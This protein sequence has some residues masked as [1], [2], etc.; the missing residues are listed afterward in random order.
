M[1]ICKKVP[2]DSSSSKEWSSESSKKK[3]KKE[4]GSISN[5]KYNRVKAVHSQDNIHF[6]KEAT[7]R[8][9]QISARYLSSQLSMKRTT[10]LHHLKMPLFKIGSFAG[11]KKK[12]L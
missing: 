10:I 9:P 6:F 12:G 3:K 11:I 8:S 4:T 5:A 7:T 2:T 1:Q